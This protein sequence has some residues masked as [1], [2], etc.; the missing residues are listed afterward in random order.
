MMEEIR[1]LFR[2]FQAV[3]PILGNAIKSDQL[4]S[5]QAELTEPDPNFWIPAG[6]ALVNMNLPGYEN[7]EG[8]HYREAWW[9]R[10][11]TRRTCKKRCTR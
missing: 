5:P 1:N 10:I 4:F 2:T 6:Y 7:S 8:L 9:D 3:G 11:R